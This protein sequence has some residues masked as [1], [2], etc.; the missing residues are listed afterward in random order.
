MYVTSSASGPNTYGFISI[1]A[2]STCPANSTGTTSCVC[3][4]GYSENA[5][6]T[7]CLSTAGVIGELVST[8]N[9]SGAPWVGSGG[10]LQFCVGGYPVKASGSSTASL[11]G[12][13]GSTEYYGPFSAGSGDCSTATQASQPLG[14]A[15]CKP[16]ESFGQVNGVDT[17]VPASVN[18]SQSSMS[19][20]P[21]AASSEVASVSPSL[22]STAPSGATGATTTTTCSGG[23]C[24]TVT[25]YTGAGG[26]SL[27]STTET[28]PETPADD[29][30]VKNPQAISCMTG[31]TATAQNLTAVDS[32]FS[33]LGVV[34]FTS[35]ASCPA[36]LSAT[37]LGN[38]VAISYASICGGLNDYV[39]PILLIIALFSATAIFIGGLKV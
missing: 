18:V 2:G 14:S 25:D 12:V 9:A 33:S 4:S 10:G 32:G 16:G 29:F 22:S 11:A 30:C 13:P 35:S 7:A 3:N 24:T 15:A 20:A 39:K 26:V 27:G 19:V 1:N 23:N 36:D 37:V 31:G 6:H 17:C 38:T 8:L 34:G 21:S 5:E 28:K